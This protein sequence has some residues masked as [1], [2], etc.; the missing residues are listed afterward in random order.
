MIY[1]LSRFICMLFFRIFFRNEVIGA[2]HI[3][4]RGPVLLCANHIHVLDPPL[5]GVSIKRP[6]TF[7]AKAE[8]FKIPLI[9][10]YL[11]KLKGF[12]VKRGAPDKAAI[13]TSLQ[14]LKNGDAFVIFPEGT[15]SKTGELGPAFTGAGFIALKE[16]CTVIPIAIIGQYRLFRKMKVAIGPP[17][18]IEDL[19]GDK[20]TKENAREATERMMNSIQ[21]LLDEYRDAS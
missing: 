4:K 12:P 6:V 19:R 5:I 9:A 17:V 13:R 1:W 18:M 21:S 16:K 14:V 8:L 11:K 3:P 7:M 2:E 20:V 15:R 10:A